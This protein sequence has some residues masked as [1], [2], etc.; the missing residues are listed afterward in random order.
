MYGAYASMGLEEC[1]AHTWQCLSM[2]VRDT[3]GKV[4]DVMQAGHNHCPVL[5]SNL[6]PM[7]Q[8]IDLGM[9]ADKLNMDP[10]AAEK[11]IVNLI[12]SAR[13]SAKL[14]SQVHL[15]PCLLSQQPGC[16]CCWYTPKKCLP[17]LSWCLYQ[18]RF[19][20]GAF[21]SVPHS[22]QFLV[23]VMQSVQSAISCS[24]Y[25]VQFQILRQRV[26]AVLVNL[27][28]Q[29]SLTVSAALVRRRGLW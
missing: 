13:L 24:W 25:K 26:H 21:V 1:P 15:L 16:V 8:C 2:S 4:S 9:L 23:Q 19:M 14:D 7:A 18:V 5:F 22:E 28:Y 20:W 6:F 29:K 11:W 12:R 10:E 17:S 27:F 3:H